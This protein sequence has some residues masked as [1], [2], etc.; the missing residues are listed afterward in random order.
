[1]T[2]SKF[3]KNDF[4]RAL[5]QFP[6]GVTVITT[7]DAD[8][9]PVGVTA[10]SFNTVSMDP[11]LVL[12]SVDKNAF[13]AKI[14]EN[15]EYFAVNVLAKDQMDTSNRFASRGEDKFKD[16]D[17]RSGIGGSPLLNHFSAQF[18]CKTWNVYEGG[19]HFIIV[20]EVQNYAYNETTSPLVFS[21]SSYAITGQFPKASKDQAAQLP[22]GFV[23]D[24]LLYLLRETYSRYSNLLYP[25]FV[26]ECG[27]SAEEW[28]I[29]ILLADQP[30][31]PLKQ[32][33][34]FVMQP[35]KMLKDTTEW[36]TEKG[37]IQ[38]EGE[39]ELTLT[40]FGSELVEK[41]QTIATENEQQA[42]SSL[43][44]E[45]AQLLKTSLKTILEQ[46]PE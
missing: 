32:I 21:C 34:T 9:K 14:F 2:E 8:Q 41:L 31:T 10:S 6:T 29:L 25:R 18:E 16:V 1:M 12:W 33:A 23:G 19:D 20:G 13:S 24:L 27:I 39:G 42:L 5:S 40:V 30:K 46:L 26:E 22:N 36:M 15:A 35:V 37:Y 38:D 3:E 43:T 7:L 45:H 44:P 17:Y 11:P 4:R 28:R